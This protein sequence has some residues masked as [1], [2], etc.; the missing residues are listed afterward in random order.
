MIDNNDYTIECRQKGT[1][2]TCS[3]KSKDKVPKDLD[4]KDIK[5]L[6]ENAFKWRKLKG[7]SNLLNELKLLKVE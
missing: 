3:I 1:G 7:M 4:P 6:V 2:I 5:I